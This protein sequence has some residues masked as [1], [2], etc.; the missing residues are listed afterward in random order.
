MFLLIKKD[1]VNRMLYFPKSFQD[2]K[3]KMNY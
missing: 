3:M 2:M 1:V